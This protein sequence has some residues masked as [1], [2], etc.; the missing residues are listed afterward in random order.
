M[1]LKRKTLDEPSWSLL[2]YKTS[3]KVTGKNIFHNKNREI[4]VLTMKKKQ[5]G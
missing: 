1:L 4:S 5:Q 3:A 2:G